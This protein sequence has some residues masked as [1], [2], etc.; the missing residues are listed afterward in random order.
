MTTEDYTDFAFRALVTSIIDYKNNVKR[1]LLLKISLGSIGEKLEELDTFRPN[2][3]YREY[4]I[5][6]CRFYRRLKFARQV[7]MA[8]RTH[9]EHKDVQDVIYCLS[10]IQRYSLMPFLKQDEYEIE[11]FT[12]VRAKGEI[13]LLDAYVACVKQVPEKDL[14]N[15]MN[16]FDLRELKLRIETLSAHNKI[17]EVIALLSQGGLFNF[18]MQIKTYIIFISIFEYIKTTERGILHYY[19]EEALDSNESMLLAVLSVI[20][21]EELKDVDA[22]AETFVSVP[23]EEIPVS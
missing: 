4:L 17:N 18:T 10:I 22:Q 7:D 3:E 13:A 23:T 20:K 16:D 6:Y 5:L 2:S 11:V 12:L 14:F 21:L 19:T 9:L 15:V 8:L 1:L